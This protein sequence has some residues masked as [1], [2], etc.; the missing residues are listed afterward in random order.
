MTKILQNDF[1]NFLPDSYLVVLVVTDPDKQPKT[2][3]KNEDKLY[4]SSLSVCLSVLENGV[5][6]YREYLIIK[7]GRTGEVMGEELERK[8]EIGD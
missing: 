8:R 5:V 2:K 3:E 7:L 1:K 4:S 6:R